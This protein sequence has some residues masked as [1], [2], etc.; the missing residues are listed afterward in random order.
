MVEAS[1]FA[2]KAEDVS[3]RTSDIESV[4]ARVKLQGT[5]WVFISQHVSRSFS[6]HVF[7]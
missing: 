7:K 1:D 3:P 6:G 4:H 2:L 5:V